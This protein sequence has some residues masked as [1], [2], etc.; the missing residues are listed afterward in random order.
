MTEDRDRREAGY[1]REYADDRSG[2][3]LPRDTRLSGRDQAWQAQQSRDRA[4]APSTQQALSD[5]RNRAPMGPPE[6][7]SDAPGPTV[8]PARAALIDQRDF[9]DSGRPAPPHHDRPA[10]PGDRPPLRSATSD[11]DIGHRPD[12]YGLDRDSRSQ[13]SSRAQSPR[14]MDDRVG[15][16]SVARDERY[17]ALA[18]PQ[19]G[20]DRRDDHRG[21][22]S[23]PRGVQ[24]EHTEAAPQGPRGS[25]DL[26]QQPSH[27]ARAPVDPN[28]GRLT[29]EYGPPRPQQQQDPNYGRLSSTADAPNGPR[30]GVSSRGRGGRNFTAPQPH[31]ST[32]P[33]SSVN[34]TPIP[35]SPVGRPPTGPG[36]HNRRESTHFDPHPS[37]GS[38]PSTPASEQAPENAVGIHPSRLHNIDT[39]V[40]NAPSIQSPGFAPS[41]PRNGRHGPSTNNLPSPASRNPPNAPTGPASATTDRRAPDNRRISDINSILQGNSAPRSDSVSDRG[42][43][44]RGRS[45]RQPLPPQQMPGTSSSSPAGPLS[46]GGPA[47]PQRNDGTMQQQRPD[48]L[49]TGRGGQG[50]DSSSQDGGRSDSRGDHRSV[51]GEGDRKSSGRHGRSSSRDRDGGRRRGEQRERDDHGGRST[52]SEDQRRGPLPPPPSQQP[53]GGAGD[54]RDSRRG[55]M[56]DDQGPSRDH[57]ERGGDGHHHRGERDGRERRD[58]GGGR[59]RDEGFRG[60][61]PSQQ[62]EMRGGGGGGSE[63]HQQQQWGGMASQHQLQQA[64][65]QGQQYQQ[66]GGQQQQQQQ[67]MRNGSR[68]GVGG[69][70]G[71]SQRDD[72]ERRDG[73]NGGRDRKRGRA[74]GEDGGMG[75]GREDSKRPR[76]GQ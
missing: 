24:N 20:R 26:F 56:R 4:V 54:G 68:G 2:R 57:R 61:M 28:H 58:G 9:R 11:R 10:M 5:S 38:G 32:G 27:S 3:M 71:P 16:P 29:Q 18:H 52:P 40:P 62:Q 19:G 33:A 49:S 8:N 76:R 35:S 55:P 65:P 14:R 67:D 34:A 30:G 75:G 47:M 60:P 39:N 41:G 74:P 12:D 21:P 43:G 22:P 1:G 50:Q 73:G 64:Y 70:G 31:V 72:R 66:H 69:G 46:Q 13:R 17:D 45:S 63:Q 36:G 59:N 7:Q 37:H 15:H 6:K 42:M 44:I 51:R 53:A 48:L 25:R 23:G